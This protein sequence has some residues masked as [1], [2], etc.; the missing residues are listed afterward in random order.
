MKIL[1]TGGAG[2]IGSHVVDQYI[3]EGHEVFIIDNLTTGKKENLNFQASFHNIDIRDRKAIESFFKEVKPDILNH[4]A[5]QLNVRKSVADPSYD[6][7]VNIIGLLNLLEAGR[8]NNLRKVIFASSGGVVY[9]DAKIIPTPEDYQPLKPISPYGVSKLTSEYYLYYYFINYGLPYIALRY[10]NVYGPRQDPFGE[11]G[12]VAIFTQKLLRG[13][14]PIINGDGKQTRD[15]VFI[16]DVV[17]ANVT[18]LTSSF[19]GAINIGTGIETSVNEIFQILTK[20]TKSQAVEKHGKPRIGEQRRSA[21][22]I[23]LARQ[24]LGWQPEFDLLAGMK[25]T[26]TFFRKIT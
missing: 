8:R 15:Y 18:S 10:A 17:S 20:L 2:F 25:K 7:Q 1:V 11:A 12:V 4:H 14:Q 5:A 3:K 6:A 19:V 13:E 23:K 26:V 21:L 9:G 16:E 22:D 24:I